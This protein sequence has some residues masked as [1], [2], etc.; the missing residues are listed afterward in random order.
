MRHTRWRRDSLTNGRPWTVRAPMDSN[1][2]N[3]NGTDAAG[4]MRTGHCRTG[5]QGVAG[6]N[7]VIPTNKYRVESSL[8]VQPFFLFGHFVARLWHGSQETPRTA[9]I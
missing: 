8:S 9:A 4:R 7:P 2:C 1:S 3:F 6:S 5:G